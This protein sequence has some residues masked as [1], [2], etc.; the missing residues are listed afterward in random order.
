M[1]SCRCVDEI[2]IPRPAAPKRCRV[3]FGGNATAGTSAPGSCR[4]GAFFRSSHRFHRSEMGTSNVPDKA[5]APCAASSGI[6]YTAAVPVAAAHAR[7]E[8]P[9]TP[10]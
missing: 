4:H 10:A 1:S 3:C 6:D 7:R 2:S 9:E 8:E 5:D